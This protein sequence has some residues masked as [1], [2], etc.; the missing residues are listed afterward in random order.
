MELVNEG[1]LDYRRGQWSRR[2]LIEMTIPSSVDRTIVPDDS[3][4]HVI[5]LFTQYTPYNLKWDNAMKEKYA[6]HSELHW[7]KNYVFQF[8]RKLTT[9]LQISRKVS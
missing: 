4:A 1:V 2:P 7:N 3:N 8:S 5:L 6:R 9:M